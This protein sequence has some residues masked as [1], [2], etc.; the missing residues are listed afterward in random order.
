MERPRKLICKCLQVDELDV[1]SAIRNGATTLTE[2]GMACEAGTGCQSCH[3]AIEALLAT[4]R[5][6]RER[7]RKDPR[8]LG[9]FS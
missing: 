9:L 8:Q 3:E 1:R 5:K 4:D 2:V 7:A 6:R